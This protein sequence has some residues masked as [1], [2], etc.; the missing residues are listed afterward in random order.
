[1]NKLEILNEVHFLTNFQQ[2]Y[3]L[4]RAS[5]FP[6]PVSFHVFGSRPCSRETIYVTERKRETRVSRIT[7]SRVG[8]E[9]SENF[10]SIFPWKL[11][12]DNCRRNGRARRTIFARE[13]TFSTRSVL[14]RK[15]TSFE[16]D[17]WFFFYKPGSSSVIKPTKPVVDRIERSCISTIFSS[18]KVANTSFVHSQYLLYK[19]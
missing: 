3:P 5:P 11:Q 1:M 15:S 6:E 18:Y 12:R 9:R 2:L 7:F 16:I 8:C 19:N 10:P 14:T 17:K 13:N 4:R